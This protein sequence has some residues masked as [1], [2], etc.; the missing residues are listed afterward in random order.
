[1]K[2]IFLSAIML[3]SLPSAYAEVFT[4]SEHIDVA[5]VGLKGSILNA[6][7]SIDAGSQHQTINL[8]ITP[9]ES[10]LKNVQ[11]TPFS[12]RLINC[13]RLAS[14]GR[15]FKITFEGVQH[16]TTFL[17]MGK[18][19]GV[20]VEIADSYGNIAYSG[21]GLSE[22]QIDKENM[23]LKFQSRLMANKESIRAG[24]LRASVR[25]RMDYF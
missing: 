6:A 5:R 20:G 4:N 12:I 24:D 8:G 9:V 18:A 7:C 1:M 2:P 10:L 15:N 19:S 3:L 25:F 11:V 14:Q 23:E 22:R 16:Q 17:L 21:Q 13:A